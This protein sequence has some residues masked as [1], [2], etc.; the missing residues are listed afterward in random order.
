[1]ATMPTAAQIA[2][3]W[4][5]AY[6]LQENAQTLGVDYVIWHAKIWSVARASEGWRDYCTGGS[7]GPYGATT[8]IT[9]LHMDHVHVSVRP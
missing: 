3:G 8:N 2:F 7:C 9:E 1:M 4:Q 5:V 6:W